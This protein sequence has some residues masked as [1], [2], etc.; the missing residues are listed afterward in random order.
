MISVTNQKTSSVMQG[1]II[2]SSI[3]TVTIALDVGEVAPWVLYCHHMAHM[4]K[5]MTTQIDVRAT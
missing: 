1:A 2:V 3:G 5:G 4:A